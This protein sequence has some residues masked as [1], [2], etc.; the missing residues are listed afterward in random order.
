[1]DRALQLG[2]HAR[3]LDE[4]AGSLESSMEPIEH[5]EPIGRMLPPKIAGKIDGN[6][7]DLDHLDRHR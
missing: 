6:W 2:K 1:M 5:M 4:P 7:M 3:D